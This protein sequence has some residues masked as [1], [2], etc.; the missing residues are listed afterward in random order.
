[1]Q[2]HQLVEQLGRLMKEREGSDKGNRISSNK[3]RNQ[4]QM[5]SCVLCKCPGCKVKVHDRIYQWQSNGTPLKDLGRETLLM[6]EL[7][8]TLLCFP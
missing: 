7:K 6:Q 1:M 2:D 5:V 8:T 3:D 4:Y